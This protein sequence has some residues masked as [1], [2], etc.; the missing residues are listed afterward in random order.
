MT[1][2][3]TQ[4]FSALLFSPSASGMNRQFKG[5]PR[6]SRIDVIVVKLGF[7]GPSKGLLPID[8]SHDRAS[9]L[10]GNRGRFHMQTEGDRINKSATS[11]GVG[12]LP[13]CSASQQRI[14]TESC[15]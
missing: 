11:P 3:S 12:Q 14:G 1:L 15:A 6:R 7:E 5:L 10:G 9:G 4:V 2:I 8:Q 13:G